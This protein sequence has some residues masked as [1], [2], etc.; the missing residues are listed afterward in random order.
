[1]QI[2]L[3]LSNFLLTLPMASCGG[4]GGESECVAEGESSLAE[5][6]GTVRRG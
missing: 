3:P 1:M 6:A 5:W 2:L 4:G